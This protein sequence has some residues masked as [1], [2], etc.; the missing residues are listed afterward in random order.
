MRLKDKLALHRFVILKIKF[1]VLK[2]GRCFVNVNDVLELREAFE[3][4]A[5]SMTVVMPIQ[6]LRKEDIEFFR[7][8]LFN[9]KGKQKLSFCIKNPMDNSMIELV[10]MQYQVN[11][12]QDILEVFRG[13]NKYEVYLN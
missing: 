13:L 11:I 12:N 2:D 9:Y 10:S 8:E 4:Y 7:N 1:A 6:D 5:K 3:K